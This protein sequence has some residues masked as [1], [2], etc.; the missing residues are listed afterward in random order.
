MAGPLSFRDVFNY[1]MSG[2]IPV[3][4]DKE[5]GYPIVITA[6]DYRRIYDR[7]GPGARA[8]SIFSEACWDS[9]PE[10]IE[11]EDSEDESD[12]EKAVTAYA[13]DPNI[14][15]FSFLERLDIESGIGRFG[16][17]LLGIDDGKALNE[18]VDGLPPDGINPSK[19]KLPMATT[20]HRLIYLRVFDESKVNITKTESDPASPRYGWP[21]EYSFTYADGKSQVVHWHRVHHVSD[22]IGEP[23]HEPRMMRIFNRLLDLKKNYGGSAQATW[24]GGFPGIAFAPKDMGEFQYEI[25]PESIQDAMEK[26]IR[27]LSRY[28]AVEGVEPKSMAVQVYD[29]TPHIEVQLKAVALTIGCPYRIYIGSE[30]AQLAGS[31]DLKNMN[32]RVTKRQK[33]Y[34]TP[35]I[36][37]RLIT[38]LIQLRC[39]PEPAAMNE[40]KTDWV[41]DVKWC[42]REQVTESETVEIAAKTAEAIAKWVSSGSNTAI[43]LREFLTHVLKWDTEVVDQVVKAAEDALGDDGSGEDPNDITKPG[44]PPPKPTPFGDPNDPNNPDATDPTDQEDV[45]A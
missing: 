45:A 38:W 34:V 1:M 12:F 14:S 26:Y 29:P 3:D 17:M 25:D 37:R 13:D 9:D 39:L 2:S 16:A 31:Q 28:I 43:P 27:G 40:A 20:E 10:V 7:E 33:R 5:C 44:D 24:Q 35:V 36:V 19:E 32:K 4:V 30:E 22:R 21:T 15:L 11:S 41:Y 18:P 42:D 8:I 6:G 23:Y